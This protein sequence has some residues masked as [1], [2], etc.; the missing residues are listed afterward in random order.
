M[1]CQS[2]LHVLW[3]SAQDLD[4]DAQQMLNSLPGWVQ[5]HVCHIQFAHVRGSQTQELRVG[6]S[7]CFAGRT[8]LGMEQHCS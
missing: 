3:H 6:V 4:T 5:E 1:Q 8:G 7:A 2:W